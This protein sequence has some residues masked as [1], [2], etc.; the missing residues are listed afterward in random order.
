MRRNAE[1]AMQNLFEAMS[2]H[3]SYVTGEVVAQQEM[4]MASTN[5]T[6]KPIIW[7]NVT[8]MDYEI[9]GLATRTQGRVENVYLAPIL[10]SVD[11]L[12]PW[13]AYSS[14]HYGWIDTSREI[15]LASPERLLWDVSASESN[16]SSA[17]IIPYVY[18]YQTTHRADLRGYTRRL[19]DLSDEVGVFDAISP[20]LPDP[21]NTTLFPPPYLPAWQVSPPQH[22]TSLINADMYRF[23]SVQDLFSVLNPSDNTEPVPH[24]VFGPVILEQMAGR[25][26]SAEIKYHNL[27][28][29]SQR[30]YNALDGTVVND[31]VSDA[32]AREESQKDE[33][34]Y[35]QVPHSSFMQPVYEN[36]YDPSSQLEAVLVAGLGWDVYLVNLIP[37]ATT[38]GTSASLTVVLRNTCGQLFSFS[39]QNSEVRSLYS[40][41]FF[42]SFSVISNLMLVFEFSRQITGL[43][44]WYRRHS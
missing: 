7:P 21:V 25:Q 27:F 5:S 22:D 42:F 43:L 41:L 3:A 28:H 20:Q 24:G 30:R 29:Q 35:Y 2:S 38:G 23:T 37:A 18:N 15:V 40:C 33:Y 4:I 26:S 32:L 39:L 9:T 11:A 6:E 36:L 10:R 13:S 1:F 14:S 17:V 12:D 31:G 34:N 19:E 8:L 16:T 44:H